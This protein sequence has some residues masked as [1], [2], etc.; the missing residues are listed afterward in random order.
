[1]S[2][3]AITIGPEGDPVLPSTEGDWDRWVSASAMRNYLL[4]NP[5]IDWLERYG[6]ANGF[7]RDTA[8]SGYDERLE[9]VPFIMQKG[10]EFEAAIVEHLSWKS[11]LLTVS[12]SRDDVRDLAAAERT[13]EALAEGRPIVHQAVLRD[14]ETL[15]YGAADLLVRSDVL[16]ELF[17]GHITSDEATTPARTWAPSPGISSW[18]T[19]SSRRCGC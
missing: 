14:G 16:A 2:R 17:P 15:T 18:S 6:E 11:L 4:R 12:E 7:D 19:S 8:L 5:L 1:M 10:S 13:F 3:D 9:F